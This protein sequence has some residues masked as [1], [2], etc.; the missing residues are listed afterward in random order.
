MTGSV[1]GNQT[2]KHLDHWVQTLCKTDSFLYIVFLVSPWSYLLKKNPSTLTLNEKFGFP[3]ATLGAPQPF[4]V[5]HG[6]TH[7]HVGCPWPQ[8][9]Q[10]STSV[11]D[12][13]VG[14]GKKKTTNQQIQSK[15]LKPFPHK[16]CWNHILTSSFI[17]CCTVSRLP[18]KNMPPEDCSISLIPQGQLNMVS[19]MFFSQMASLD[20]VF[21]KIHWGENGWQH[22]PFKLS[23]GQNSTHL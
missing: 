6:S 18:G 13:T 4:Q 12:S 17:I 21:W 23:E 10:R 8:A 22:H 20:V 16:S 5:P 2:W 11:Y 14:W 9:P 15:K 7:D 1:S 3:M 19:F